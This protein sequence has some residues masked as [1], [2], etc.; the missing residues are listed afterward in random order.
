VRADDAVVE[1]RSGDDLLGR[2]R[3]I[4]VAI[5]DDRN[6]AGADPVGR[7]ARGACLDEVY[8]LTLPVQSTNTPRGCWPSINSMADFG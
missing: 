8:S 6:V 4:R 7:L 1:G 5:D 3:E 2:V